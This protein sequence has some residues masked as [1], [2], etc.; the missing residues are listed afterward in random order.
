MPKPLTLSIGGQPAETR[1]AAEEH[2]A[3]SA[4]KIEPAGTSGTPVSPAAESPEIYEIL[5]RHEETLRDLVIE[6]RLLYHNLSDK[7]RQRLEARR[8]GT[9]REV[10]DSFAGQIR[11]LEEKIARLRGAR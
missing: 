5:K 6:V 10:R 11:A 1:T 8:D 3:E 9:T 7:E 4:G 2:Q